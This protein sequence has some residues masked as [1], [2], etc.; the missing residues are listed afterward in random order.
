MPSIISTI[1]Y[2]IEA[3]VST[4]TNLSNNAVIIKGMIACNR[5]NQNEPLFINFIAF[6]PVDKA[7]EEGPIQLIIPNSAFLFHGK[8]VYTTIK[9]S[10]N[11]VKQELQVKINNF[12]DINKIKNRDK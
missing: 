2:I 6:R 4:S 9:N 11:K 7:D 3:D 10:N 5:L 12:Y 1:G 8:F